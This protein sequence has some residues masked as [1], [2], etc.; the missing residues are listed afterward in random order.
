LPADANADQKIEHA[1]K[2][3]LYFFTTEEK[4][5]IYYANL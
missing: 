5:R 4:M 3:E 1:S 2:K